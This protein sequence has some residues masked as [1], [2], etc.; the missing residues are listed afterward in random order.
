MRL[1]KRSISRSDDERRLTVECCNRSNII[2]PPRKFCHD[3]RGGQSQLRRKGML[4]LHSKTIKRSV[5]LNKN[6]GNYPLARD[7]RT[8]QLW[9][10][11]NSGPWW[12]S[13]LHGEPRIQFRIPRDAAPALRHAPTPFD[14][15]LLFLLMSEAQATKKSALEFTSTAAMLHASS[16]PSAPRVVRVRCG[17]WLFNALLATGG[18]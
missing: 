18:C 9:R 12:W 2:S 13:K 14:M 11:S 3:T 1:L 7:A 5:Q 8:R 15:N 17:G 10:R 6:L 4:D 16:A